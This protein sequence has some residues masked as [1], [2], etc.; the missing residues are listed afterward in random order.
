MNGPET[1][2]SY[3]RSQWIRCW[4]TVPCSEL[5]RTPGLEPG[6]PGCHGACQNATDHTGGVTAPVRTQHIIPEGVTVKLISSSRACQNTT[7]HTG[8]GHGSPQSRR[9]A[10]VNTTDHTGGGHGTPQSRRAAPVNTTDHTGGGQN[11]T[12]HTEGGHGVPQSRISFSRAYQ[13]KTDHTGGGHGT[14]PD[15]RRLPTPLK[16]LCSY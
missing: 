10:P 7:D 8:G 4:I 3:Q 1:C 2:T 6:S 14:P 16:V 12:N 15:S 13:N 11:T 9:A 5:P